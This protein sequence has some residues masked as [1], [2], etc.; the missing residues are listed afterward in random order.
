[1]KVLAG[2]FT[3]SLTGR[4]SMSLSSSRHRRQLDPA[5]RFAYRALR[6]ISSGEDVKPARS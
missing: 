1:V 6:I 2:A 5:R 4:S 3:V